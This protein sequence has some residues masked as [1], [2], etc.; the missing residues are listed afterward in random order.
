MGLLA[1]HA[2]LFL[3][4]RLFL[5]EAED[6]ALGFFA[7]GILVSGPWM[8]LARE[9][10]LKISM[11]I[12]GFLLSSVVFI[13]AYR[14]LTHLKFN[15]GQVLENPIEA[16]QSI[17]YFLGETYTFL[18]VMAFVVLGMALA[19]LGA[20]LWRDM[21]RRW[22][23]DLTPRLAKSIEYGVTLA[24]LAPTSVFAAQLIRHFL[25]S[26]PPL[27]VRF[28]GPREAIP[29]RDES[30]ILLQLESLNGPALFRYEDG[31]LSGRI[32]LPAL[33]RL[34]AL[35]GTWLPFF[36]ANT[37]GTNL[38]MSSILC[39]TSGSM[40]SKLVSPADGTPCLPERFRRAG[41]HTVF[42]YSFKAAEFYSMQDHVGVLG[43]DEFLFGEKLMKPGDP[44]WTWGYED[45][46]FYD[47]AFADMRAR[48][49][50]RKKKMFIYT[51][52]HRIRSSP[53]C[54]TCSAPGL[55]PV[56]SCGRCVANRR[57]RI[58]ASAI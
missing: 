20:G 33:E 8:P 36:W 15:L 45:C 44:F 5:S 58:T 4:I 37:F 40:L 2:A 53:Q 17:I 54:W 12:S 6:L 13:V 51:S 55:R 43:F 3:A 7:V 21:G 22:R 57:H 42:Y 31:G 19:G 56:P 18:A 14:V 32:P 50:D 38:G 34:K 30:L 39:G 46:R 47:R 24:L 35:G 10:V 27:E 1:V 11:L 25:R 26:S 52:V 23:R 49:L 9:R 16:I 29:R 28:E 48:G 41:F